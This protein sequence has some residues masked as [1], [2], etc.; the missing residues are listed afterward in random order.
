MN[1]M[2][3]LKIAVLSF[4]MIMIILIIFILNYSKFRPLTHV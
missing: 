1:I 4:I 3:I 2:L